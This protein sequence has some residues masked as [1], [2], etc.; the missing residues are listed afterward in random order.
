ME[1]SIHRDRQG[2]WIKTH[3]KRRLSLPANSPA[4][5]VLQGGVHAAELG[6]PL[7]EDGA[8]N[9]V[10]TAQ[11][12]YGGA[13]FGLLENGQ[14]LA[15]AESGRLHAELPRV[16]WQKILLLMTVVFRGDYHSISAVAAGGFG[17]G[18]ADVEDFHGLNRVGLTEIKPEDWPVERRCMRG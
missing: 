5:A 8:A 13:R 4:G 10:L 7:V 18:V 12:R 15:I 2:L 11:I 1:R 14:D 16:V 9:P 6:A 17:G 3:A